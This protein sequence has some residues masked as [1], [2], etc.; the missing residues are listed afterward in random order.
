MVLY[1]LSLNGGITQIELAKHLSVTAPS[2]GRLLSTMEDN[3]LVT[4]STHDDDLRIRKLHLTKKGSKL[5]K[6]CNDIVIQFKNDISK[7]ISQQ[8][9]DNMR[10]T[11]DKM[12]E[13]VV[14]E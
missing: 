5:G 10:R 2:L 14:A 7:G 1:Y 11:L 13:N 3:G 4:R 9:L 6:E 12:V 8:E